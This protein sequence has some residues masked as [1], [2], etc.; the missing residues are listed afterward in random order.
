MVSPTATAVLIAV[1]AGLLVAYL[2]GHA[3]GKREGFREGQNSGKKEAAMK[4]YAVGFDRGK[5]QR[6][7]GSDATRDET[8]PRGCSAVFFLLGLTTVVCLF[9]LVSSFLIGG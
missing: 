4:A 1:V 2:A 3:A 6:E 8:Q 5:R 7:E 9:N